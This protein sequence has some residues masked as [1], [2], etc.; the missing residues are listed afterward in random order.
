MKKTPAPPSLFTLLT[1]PPPP[2]PPQT[3][4][5]PPQ[6]PQPISQTVQHPDIQHAPTKIPQTSSLL[7]NPENPTRTPFEG[8]T[9]APKHARVPRVQKQQPT[10]QQIKEQLS[11]QIEMIPT[12]DIHPEQPQLIIKSQRQPAHHKGIGYHFISKIDQHHPRASDLDDLKKKVY[13]TK[14]DLKHDIQKTLARTRPHPHR[15]YDPTK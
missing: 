1:P 9:H 8:T 14:V 7:F 15:P 2:K 6:P 13:F 10:Q 4:V 11:H 3:P 12:A 5:Q